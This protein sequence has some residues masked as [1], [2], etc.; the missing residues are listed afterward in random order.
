MNLVQF[1][2]ILWAR[3]W[4]IIVS[5]V[6]CFLAGVLALLLL[7]KYY[8]ASA[9]VLLNVTSADPTAPSDATGYFAKNYF[10][11]QTKVIEDYGVARRTAQNL[12]WD[13]SPEVRAQY[14]EYQANAGSRALD[15]DHWLASRISGNVNAGNMQGTS[16]MDI[17]YTAGDPDEAARMA[18]AV[19][20]GYIDEDL[21]SKR[22]GA[23]NAAAW[24]ERQMRDV[25]RQREVA[26]QRL[27]AF[28]RANGITMLSDTSDAASTHLQVLTNQAPNFGSTVVGGGGGNPNGA[29]LAALDAKIATESAALGPNHPTIRDLKQQRAAIASSA[30]GV[31]PARVINGPSLSA[32]V[33]AARNKVLAERDKVEEAKRLASDVTVLRDQYTKM[34]VT[35]ADLRQQALRTESTMVPMESAVPPNSPQFPKRTLVLFG[36]LALGLGLGLFVALIVELMRRRVR[37]VEDLSATEVPII[38][39]INAPPKGL[40]ALA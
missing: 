36:S 38:G 15:F 13:K 21:A 16:I 2:R 40:L 31:V 35:A 25:S 3:R 20:Q 29:Q 14:A 10:P 6:S 27:V 32:A 28:E 23:N 1:F 22:A 12:G 4:I 5:T 37:G 18:N 8:T 9:R 39:V 19:R 11:S 17:S 34:A 7:P 26:E 24:F 30:S 33:S